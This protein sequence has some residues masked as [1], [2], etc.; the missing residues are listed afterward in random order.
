MIADALV[1]DSCFEMQSVHGLRFHAQSYSDDVGGME[2]DSD[3]LYP[4]E[5][6]I[7]DFVHRAKIVRIPF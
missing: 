1:Q 7:S 3:S 4:D 5:S 2:S 6:G